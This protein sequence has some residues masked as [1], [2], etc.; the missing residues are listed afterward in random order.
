MG[1]IRSCSVAVNYYRFMCGV[2]MTTVLLQQR[3][4]QHSS[5]I[6]VYLNIFRIW[7]KI[8]NERLRILIYN[9]FKSVDT[10]YLTSVILSF[11]LHH[12]ICHLPTREDDQKQV[13]IKYYT[14]TWS[15]SSLCQVSLGQSKFT[16]LTEATRMPR[17]GPCWLGAMTRLQP[18]CDDLTEDSHA[19]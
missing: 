10:M 12:V 13:T 19:R 6:Y 14:V 3:R 9:V 7:T 16:E 5:Q 1:F 18:T 15:S 4:I 17:Y 11:L 2:T 8:A